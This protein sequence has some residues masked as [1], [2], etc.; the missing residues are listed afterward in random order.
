MIENLSYQGMREQDAMTMNIRYQ[1]LPSDNSTLYQKFNCRHGID[2]QKE[3]QYNIN[4][5]LDPNSPDFKPK[6]Q[7]RGKVQRARLIVTMS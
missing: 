7:Y 2:V 5:W 4:D 1:L 3:P 6:I